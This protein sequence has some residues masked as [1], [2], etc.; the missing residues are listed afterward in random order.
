MSLLKWEFTAITSEEFNAF[1][2][3]EEEDKT[4][5]NTM[6]AST[7]IT[8]RNEGHV[9]TMHLNQIYR[10]D[11]RGTNHICLSCAVCAVEETC[12][13][14]RNEKQLRCVCKTHPSFLEYRAIVEQRLPRRS[15][16]NQW[17]G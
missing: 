13:Y 10:E 3:D 6:S 15:E 9:P 4:L 14:E 16:R 12:I 11:F 2:P 7:L 17:M 5:T 8:R 1:D